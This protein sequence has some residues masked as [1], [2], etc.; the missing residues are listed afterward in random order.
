MYNSAGQRVDLQQAW[1]Q[2]AAVWAELGLDPG[3]QP[4]TP[5]YFDVA[6]PDALM[7]QVAGWRD[8]TEEAFV[9]EVTGLIRVEFQAAGEQPFGFLAQLLPPQADAHA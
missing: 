2:L 3:A 4:V 7:D 6:M 1:Q 5:H 9:A 8:D